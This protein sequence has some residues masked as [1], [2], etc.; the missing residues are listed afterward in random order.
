MDTA[1]TMPPAAWRLAW[2]PFIL[3]ALLFVGAPDFPAFDRAVEK[4]FTATTRSATTVASDHDSAPQEDTLRSEPAPR[5]KPR[6]VLVP[7]Y[8]SFAALQALDAHSTMRALDAG[9]RETNPLMRGIARTPAALIAVKA[10]LTA[11]TIYLVERM[12]VKS[13]RAAIVI[14]AALNSTYA[15]IVAHNYTAADR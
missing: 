9:A 7:L 8:A 13:R 3:L 12:R 5:A 1:H 14:M 2:L 6:G 10:G 4:A 11:T 15:T